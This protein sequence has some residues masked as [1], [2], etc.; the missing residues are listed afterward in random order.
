MTKGSRTSRYNLRQRFRALSSSG[1]KK[2]PVQSKDC[3]CSPQYFYS[4]TG[5]CHCTIHHPDN[6]EFTKE[7]SGSPRSNS[8]VSPSILQQEFSRNL[9]QATAQDG[10][11]N[12]STCTS[13]QTAAQAG[14]PSPSTSFKALQRKEDS[15]SSNKTPDNTDSSSNSLD[16]ESEHEE[17]ES[18]PLILSASS[19]NKVRIQEAIEKE[20]ERSHQP[21][22]SSR[23]SSE[24][25]LTACSMDHHFLSSLQENITELQRQVSRC[26]DVAQDIDRNYPPS[27]LSDTVK[28]TLFHGYESENFE[29]WLEKFTLH[30]QRRRLRP[31]SDAALLN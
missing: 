14:Q 31:T 29:R 2:Q 1:K 16:S 4:N 8:P 27:S 26:T 21:E 6:T 12:P 22:F 9:N 20:K 19:R 15:S 25:D 13:F 10:H 5:I 24:E 3:T 11:I 23:S 17:K 18:T 7:T 28:P 30:L